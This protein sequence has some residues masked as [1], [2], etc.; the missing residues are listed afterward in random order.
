MIPDF[1]IL[2]FWEAG[3]GIWEAGG[4]TCDVPLPPLNASG[5]VARQGVSVKTEM[6]KG[7]GQHHIAQ[8]SKK[9]YLFACIFCPPKIQ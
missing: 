7:D 2:F 5:S 4:G 3:S 1:I 9:G 8:S 6:I